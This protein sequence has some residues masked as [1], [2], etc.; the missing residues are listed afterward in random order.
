MIFA[1]KQDGK[2]TIAANLVKTPANDG[3]RVLPLNC[4]FYLSRLDSAVYCSRKP[5]LIDWVRTG[6]RPALQPWPGDT[7][8]SILPA[9]SVAPA[10]ETRVDEAV[11]RNIR[12][13]ARSSIISSWTVRPCLLSLTVWE[14][15]QT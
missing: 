2:T 15:P 13:S 7:T 8:F 12:H 1:S 6:V 14:V 9:G 4:D 10:P 11:P 3:K 5:G